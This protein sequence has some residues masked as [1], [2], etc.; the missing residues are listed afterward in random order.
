MVFDEVRRAAK[1][2]QDKKA[3]MKLTDDEWKQRLTPE[4]YRILR[5]K[6]TEASFTGELL[7]KKDTGT[8][9]CAACGA[10][11]FMSDH[12]FESGTGW[13][14]FYDIAGSDAVKLLDDDTHGM[15]RVEVQCANCGSHLGRVFDDVPNQPTGKR[16]CINSV[17]LAFRPDKDV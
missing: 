11:L 14:S 10:T 12:K 4:Q 16:Y 8:Y 5:E 3:Q 6:G 7:D 9:A 17:C 15:H 2:S 13:P 1:S